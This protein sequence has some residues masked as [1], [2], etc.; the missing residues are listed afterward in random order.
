MGLG[1]AL[2]LQM[3]GA[4][5]S[6]AVNTSWDTTVYPILVVRLHLSWV[7]RLVPHAQKAAACNGDEHSSM[8]NLSEQ[9]RW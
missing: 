4:K 7:A 5:I 8:A 9:R 1:G 2:S 3:G 6:H